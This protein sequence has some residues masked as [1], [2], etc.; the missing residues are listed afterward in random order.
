MKIE[1]AEFVDGVKSNASI[2]YLQIETPYVYYFWFI[3][4]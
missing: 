1:G 3:G 4:N 2:S